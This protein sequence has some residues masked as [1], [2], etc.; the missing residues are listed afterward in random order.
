MKKITPFLWFND[1]AEQA[2]TLYVSLFKNSKITHVARHGESGPGK[3]GSAM[4]VKFKLDGQEFL[5]LNGGPHFQL[6]EAIS[7]YV[8]CKD[9]KEVDFFWKKLTQGG[10]QESQCGWLKDKF[11]LSWQ[12]IPEALPKLMGSKKGANVMQAMMK[13]RKIVIKDLERAHDGE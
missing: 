9:Q 2:A 11:G 6:T 8:N 13:M 7:M 12:I 10:G 3:K 5:A 4:T 1:N